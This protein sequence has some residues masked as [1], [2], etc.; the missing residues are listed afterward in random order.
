MPLSLLLGL[1]LTDS[2]LC[3]PTSQFWGEPIAGRHSVEGKAT[4]TSFTSNHFSAWPEH[5]TQ[6]LSKRGFRNW[7]VEI[8]SFL[9]WSRAAA[10][11]VPCLE[12]ICVRTSG[13]SVLGCIGWVNS[14]WFFVAPFEGLLGEFHTPLSRL[15]KGEKSL[16]STP[17]SQLG[18]LPRCL[19]LYL[20]LTQVS[21]CL[22]LWSFQG[23]PTSQRSLK[24]GL[25]L[26][27]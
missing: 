4:I 2:F 24:I 9:R 23:T 7:T 19:S 1:K 16:E 6:N 3:P 8:A 14:C 18:L 10:C 12:D 13:G 5:V 22:L 21:I 17:S 25:G 20:N 26:W 11:V 27:W 15:Q